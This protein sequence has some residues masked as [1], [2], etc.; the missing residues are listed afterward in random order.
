MD[1][2]C[3]CHIAVRKTYTQPS[4]ALIMYKIAKQSCGLKLSFTTS[5]GMSKFTGER[6]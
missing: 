3:M 4:L 6:P 5:V 2:T 1:V